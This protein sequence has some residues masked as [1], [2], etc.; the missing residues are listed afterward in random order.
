MTPDNYTIE[1]TFVPVGDG[2]TLYVHDWGN[3]QAPMPIV[4]LHGGPGSGCNNKYKQGFNPSVQRVI[5]F[6]QRGSGRSLPFGSLKHNT[7][8]HLVN[9]I[10]IISENRKLSKFIIN[11][12][13]WGSCLAVSYAL[14]HPSR[15][16]AMVLSGIFTGSQAEIDWI[17]KGQYRSFFPDVWQQ[18]LAATPKSHH[19]D[20]S[21]Y[22]YQR[23]LGNNPQD[24]KA[25]AYAFSCMEG[26]LLSLDDRF[27]PTDFDTYDP[28]GT[29]IEMHYLANHCF[30]P[31][32]HILKHAHTLR[33]P[34]WLVQGRYD[35]V[36]RPDTAYELYQ[37]LPKGQ[38]IWTIGGHRTEHETWNLMRTLSFQLADA[39]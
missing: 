11:G 1:E 12:S 16:H 34:I 21:S 36:C 33:M 23:V 28:T 19:R 8:Q 27:I 3:P 38:I 7:T 18:Y 20:P 29:L 30:L 37:K 35:F 17:D 5:F 39:L 25:S 13:S 10:E 2:H 6:D 9:D 31:D 32:R 26:A 24:T 4:F 15:I 14:Q 22:H